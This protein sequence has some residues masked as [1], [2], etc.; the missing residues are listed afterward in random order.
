M[1][2]ECDDE[3]DLLETLDLLEGQLTATI[4]AEAGDYEVA[5]KLLNA[6]QHKAGRVCFNNVPTG[7]EVCHSIVH[8]GPFPSTTD[9]R[10]TS[11][12][13]GAILRWVRPVAYQNFPQELLPARLKNE[14]TS[15][16]FR[17]VNDQLSQESI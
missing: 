6:L 17:I 16:A 12:G 2:V 9:A 3:H 10:F 1:L 4:I 5:K 14:N 11:V 8:G 7:V 15:N 13:H